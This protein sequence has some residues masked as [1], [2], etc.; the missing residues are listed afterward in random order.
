MVKYSKLLTSKHAYAI[1]WSIVNNQHS[2]NDIA[3]FSKIH[4]KNLNKTLRKMFW[5]KTNLNN[6]V[7]FLTRIDSNYFVNH[8]G[9]LQFIIREI[10]QIPFIL[11]RGLDR[12]ILKEFKDYFFLIGRYYSLYQFFNW[13][14]LHCSKKDFFNM[15][16]PPDSQSKEINEDIF[17]SINDYDVVSDFLYKDYRKQLVK[18]KKK[19][20]RDILFY[21]ACMAYVQEKLIIQ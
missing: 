6:S 7:E 11:K 14:I 17:A 9:M 3:K 4:P 16:L 12:N 21:L 10:L 19:Y 18:L 15:A 1:V 20:A 2:Y 13:F 8:S 5:S